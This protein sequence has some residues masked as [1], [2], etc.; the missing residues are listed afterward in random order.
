MFSAMGANPTQMSWA[1][2]QP[3]LSSGAVD[4]QENPLFLFTILKMHTVGQKF[5][6]TWGYMADPLVFV[7]NKDI[8]NSWTPADQAIVKQAAVDAGVQEISLA[9]KG[10]V[11]ADKPVLKDIAA[12]GV[13]VTQLSPAEREAF[14]KVT[15]PVYDKWKTTVGL[16]LVKA[17]ERDIAAR[18]K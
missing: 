11:E 9:R 4:G 13:T 10:L 5:V 16:D 1:D 8:W 12:M 17:A 15:R 2:A 14:V 6:T 7:V 18:K 3:A